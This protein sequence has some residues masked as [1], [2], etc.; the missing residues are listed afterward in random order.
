MLRTGTM[1]SASSGSGRAGAAPAAPGRRG[2]FGARAGVGARRRCR[3]SGSS[4]ADRH[5]FIAESARLAQAQ[6]QAA[7]ACIRGRSFEL[8][9]RQRDAPLEVAV[10]NLQPPHRARRCRRTAAR[11]GAHD[12]RARLG[13]DLDLR[14]GGTPGSATTMTISRSSSNTS[15]GGSHSACVA[16]GRGQAEELPVH[17]LGF[18]DQLAAPAPTSSRSDRFCST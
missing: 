16:L 13:R 11:L 6:Y 3:G 8:R 9:R 18:V 7:V 1:I 12:E 15:T 2:R 4:F 5:A 17:P 14:S 10:G